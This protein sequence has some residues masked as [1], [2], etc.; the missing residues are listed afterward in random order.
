VTNIPQVTRVSSTDTEVTVV[1]TFDGAPDTEYVLDFDYGYAADQGPVQYLGA[2]TITT[3]ADGSVPYSFTAPSNARGQWVRAT[4]SRGTTGATGEQSQPV[5]EGS[6][7]R[8]D[9]ISTGTP[10]EGAPVDLRLR[11]AQDEV[12]D[13]KVYVDC[14][15]DGYPATPT[16]TGESVDDTSC[17]YDTPGAKTIKLKLTDE[18]GDT[19]LTE[20][21]TVADV[22]TSATVDGPAS[23]GE[24]TTKT[25]TYTSGPD[26]PESVSA[27]CGDQGELVDPASG[28][29]FTCRLRGGTA[30]TVSLTATDDGDAGTATKT[31]AVDNTAPTVAL[32]GPETAREGDTLTY[33]WT[34][35]DVVDAVKVTGDCGSGGTLVPASGDGFSCRFGG[36]AKSVQVRAIA[37]DGTDK[38][39]ASRTVAVANVA[40]VAAGEAFATPYETAL[41]GAVLANDTDAGGDALTARVVRAPAHGTVALAADG[42]FTYTPAAGYAGPDGFGYVA[43]DGDADSG[44][45]LVAITVGDGPA[46]NRTPAG[47]RTTASG[48]TSTGSGAVDRKGVLTLRVRN[49]NAF[50]VSARVRLTGTL[51]GAS[52][53]RQLVGKDVVLAPGKTTSVRLRLDQRTRA[54]L[55]GGRKVRA[56]SSIALHDASGN[57]RR[58]GGKITLRAAR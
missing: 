54:V 45:A 37:D 6:K 53:A 22:A 15:A 12:D 11:V 29:S 2:T 44:E 47:F 36:A 58:I 7:P 56:T 28:G 20:A 13:T 39:T 34:A 51:P 31:V 43:G 24:G 5:H 21:I 10:Q 8:V 9:S 50:W 49:T 26:A 48:V 3:D 19:E 18:E 41:R 42:S 16:A 32:A 57:L 30:T 55:R 27:S 46:A 33:M 4:A 38:T 17:V 25:F 35:S 40:P 52:K 14:E 23:A 1:G